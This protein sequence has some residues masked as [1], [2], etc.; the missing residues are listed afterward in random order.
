MGKYDIDYSKACVIV[1]NMQ[2]EN[3]HKVAYP[4]ILPN[5]KRIIS[6]AHDNDVPVIYGQATLLPFEA[7]T[8]Y[9]LYAYVKRGFEPK[10]GY[11][12]RWNGFGHE[13]KFGWE[14]IKELTP[15][16]NDIVIKKSTSSFFVGTMLEEVLH[17]K[18]VETM[19]LTGVATEHG[20]DSTAR[21]ATCLGFIPV[22]PEDA[23][24]SQ[25]EDLHKNSL[26]ILKRAFFVE[27]TTTD[28]I[29]RKISRGEGSNS[30]H[31]D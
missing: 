11:E 19:I 3:G 15:Q 28:D 8:K 2:N 29:V 18:G 9:T 13:G 23:V 5:V 30:G 16:K 1:Y 27:I 31:Q 20:L 4:K 26:E 10:T 14:I 7:L 24:Y 17:S 21:H 12:E 6:V 25:N 22:I